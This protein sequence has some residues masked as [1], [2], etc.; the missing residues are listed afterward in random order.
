MERDAARWMSRSWGKKL[1]AAK[2]IPVAEEVAFAV[3]NP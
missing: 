1:A 2:K 3:V